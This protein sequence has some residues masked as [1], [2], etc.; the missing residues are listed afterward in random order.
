M[1]ELETAS[2]GLLVPLRVVS[3]TVYAMLEAGL[4]LLTVKFCVE[5]EPL[6]AA[7]KLKD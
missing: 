6:A 5:P 2:H 1:P 4:V 7:V 3:V